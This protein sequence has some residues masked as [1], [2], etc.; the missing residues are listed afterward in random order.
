MKI[1]LQLRI[2]VDLRQTTQRETILIATSRLEPSLSSLAA[3]VDLDELPMGF[4]DL[5]STIPSELFQLS[6]SIFFYPS[7]RR[8][9]GSLRALTTLTKIY[10]LSI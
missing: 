4:N 1:L 2:H 6:I 9:F 10:F 5:I 3:Q 7:Y 8:L